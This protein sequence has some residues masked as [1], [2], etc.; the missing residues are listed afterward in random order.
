M[1]NFRTQEWQIS[2]S[3]IQLQEK[4]QTIPTWLDREMESAGLTCKH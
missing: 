1:K 4:A 2:R 3:F